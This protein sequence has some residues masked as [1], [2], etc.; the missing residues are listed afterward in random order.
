MRGL[1][2]NEEFWKR[3][4][5]YQYAK[6]SLIPASASTRLEA[7]SGLDARP[8]PVRI[9][10][11]GSTTVAARL[12][13]AAARQ[14]KI[15]ELAAAVEQAV[16]RQP[17]WSGGKA[18]LAWLRVRQG[19]AD[20]GRRVLDDLLNSLSRSLELFDYHALVVIGQELKDDP[21]GEPLAV[22]V[23][24]RMLKSARNPWGYTGARFPSSPSSSPGP[25]LSAS[26]PGRGRARLAPSGRGLLSQHEH[27][28]ARIDLTGPGQP[29]ARTPERLRVVPAGD[30]RPGRRH[31]G[32]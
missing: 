6:A 13:E 19:R 21:G 18:L 28:D 11:G 1:P 31:A 15:D 30:R 24:E 3:P 25:A 8:A 32:L 17:Q 12:L 26:R 29:E 4:E 5:A 10:T 22:A 27:V 7:W 14:D 9:P 2:P 20:L 23:Y 16:A